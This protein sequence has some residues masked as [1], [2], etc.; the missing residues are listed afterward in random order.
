MCETISPTVNIQ[1]QNEYMCN[2]HEV[3][4]SIL[5]NEY[6]DYNNMEP[7]FSSKATNMKRIPVFQFETKVGFFAF[8]FFIV[9]IIVI[10][11]SYSL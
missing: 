2:S 8:F 10:L 1:T 11:P 3:S 5:S 6:R 9:V 7:E 4:T